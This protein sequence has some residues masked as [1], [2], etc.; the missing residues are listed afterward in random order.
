MTGHTVR[1]ARRVAAPPPEVFAFLAD[2]ENHWALTSHWVE[3][4]RLHRVDGGP[5]R[6]ARVRLRGPLALRRTARTQ[7]LELD[8]PARVAGTAAVGRRTSARVAWDLE[9]DGTGTLVC[10][11]AEVVS[12]APLDRLLWILVGHR[13]MARGFPAVL[14]RLESVLERRASGSVALSPTALRPATR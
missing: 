3:V 6:G 8:P 7:L 5:A 9:P 13:V 2:L 1:A 14:A 11:S 4:L 12:L 10:L